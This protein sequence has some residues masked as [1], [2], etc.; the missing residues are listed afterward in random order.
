MEL[1][2]IQEAIKKSLL[3]VGSKIYKVFAI[4]VG[5]LLILNLIISQLLRPIA[6]YILT[7]IEYINNG[8]M[9]IPQMSKNL[10]LS[11]LF[12]V[13]FSADTANCPWLVCS[14]S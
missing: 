2:E 14:L 7:V 9:D 4:Y 6:R 12:M 11:L 1:K 5:I 10:Y 8:N 3:N 13:Y